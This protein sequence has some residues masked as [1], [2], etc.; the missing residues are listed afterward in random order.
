V[1]GKEFIRRVRKLARKRG[2]LFE[3]NESAGK[4]AHRKLYFG[5]CGTTLPGLGELKTGTFQG[6][7]KQLGIDPKEL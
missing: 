7:C 5:S 6:L 2:V 3:V 4:G 1:T